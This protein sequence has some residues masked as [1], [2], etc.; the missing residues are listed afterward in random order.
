MTFNEGMQIDP[1]RASS[2]GGPGMGGKL[3]LGGGA[4]GLILLVITLLLG[5]D[6]GSVL[7]NFTGAQNPQQSQPGT[8]GTPAH[9][10]TGA[11]ANKYVD[12][13]VVATAQSLDGVWSQELPKQ[14]GKR[15]VEPKLVLFSGAVA[16][17][18]G[19][20]TSDVGPFYC[21]A[22]QTAY[23]D[24]SFF[25]ELTDRFGASAGPL[26]QEYVVA[27]EVGHHLQNQLGDIGKAQ[28]DPKGAQSGAVR[29]EL[30]ADCYAGI[31]AHYADKQ[32]APGSSQ[33][34]L[35]PLS[36]T[37]IRDALSAANAVGDDRIQRAAG[38]GVN[39]ESWTHG[40]SEQRQKWFLT[41]YRTG[42][43]QSCDTYSAGDLNNPPGLR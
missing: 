22:D 40:S 20:A 5:G 39:P 13:R 41:G 6:P 35:K 16:T 9:C 42:S 31:W 4:G 27:H 1:D 37:D 18:C 19:N 23:F 33:P 30:Q 29:T 25:Q 2:G 14:T 24:T 43:V 32:P 28:R 11:D 10:K 38:R 34:F 15:Y 7:G 21:P 12:C 17:G 26:A 3:A 8:A 36:D